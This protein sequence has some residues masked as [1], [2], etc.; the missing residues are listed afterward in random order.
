MVSI[1]SIYSITEDSN[2]RSSESGTYYDSNIFSSVKSDMTS[3]YEDMKSNHISDVSSIDEKPNE[4]PDQCA[5]MYKYKDGSC[6]PLNLLEQIATEYNKHN[7]NKIDLERIS[8][9][10]GENHRKLELVRQ[11]E[12]RYNTCDNHRCIVNSMKRVLDMNTY[13][14]LKDS[15][16]PEG[17]RDN[18]EW[19]SNFNIEDF[20]GQVMK[21]HTDFIFF[22]AM[23]R[24]FDKLEMYST[25]NHDYSKFKKEGKTKFGWVMNLDKHGQGGSHW[26]AVYGDSELNK[27][28]FFD[29]TGRRPYKEF[30][31]LMKR[32]RNQFSKMNGRKAHMYV[33][34]IPH[35]QKNTECGVY[36]SYMIS[37]FLDGTG[38]KYFRNK[39]IR[40]DVIQNYRKV[41]FNSK[42]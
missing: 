25:R 36:S 17:P 40:D 14:D 21:V 31:V 15:F 9:I 10:K 37:K 29:S 13:E 42:K 24:D 7:R 38:E 27:I 18:N 11:L 1:T 23:P 34:K 20:F 22:G 30:R 19:L 12:Q 16:R 8:R 5:P 6:I 3:V 2:G 35:Q 26:V 4:G 33:N 32:M 39:I 41:M 28:Y